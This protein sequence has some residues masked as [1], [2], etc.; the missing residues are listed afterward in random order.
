MQDVVISTEIVKYFGKSIAINNI[1]GNNNNW[2]SLCLKPSGTK[3]LYNTI[4]T[5]KIKEGS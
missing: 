2:F 3:I 4:S 5:W 1:N